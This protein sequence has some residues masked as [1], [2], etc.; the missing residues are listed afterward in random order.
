MRGMIKWKPFNSLLNSKDIKEI[1][2]KRNLIQKP[3]I[4]EDQINKINFILLESINKNLT[5]QIKYFHL[6][7]LKN[8][9]GKLENINQIEKYILINKTRIY[10]KDLINIEIL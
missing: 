9:T 3:N 1:I 8:I 6:G 7:T 10:F 5:I 2:N 4:M